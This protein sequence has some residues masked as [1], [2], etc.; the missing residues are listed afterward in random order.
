MI[1]NQSSLDSSKAPNYSVLEIRSK[2]VE[3]IQSNDLEIKIKSSLQPFELFNL[4]ETY[5]SSFE[6]DHLLKYIRKLSVAMCY[7]EVKN[8]FTTHDD[9]IIP[10]EIKQLIT[11]QT[12]KLAPYFDVPSSFLYLERLIILGFKANEDSIRAM[13]QISKHHINN[14]GNFTRL[15]EG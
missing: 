2:Q 1:P 6:P 8:Q 15:G 9:L 4:L 5:H 14:L 13:L 12:I 11:K 10:D 3:K 7:D